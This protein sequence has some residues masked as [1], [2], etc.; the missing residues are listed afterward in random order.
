[1]GSAGGVHRDLSALAVHA[2]VTR[3]LRIH[4]KAASRV[5][6]DRNADA[7]VPAKTQRTAYIEKGRAAAR[8]A[9]VYRLAVGHRVVI[10]IIGRYRIIY[11][12][13]RRGALTARGTE[14]VIGNIPCVHIHTIA[15]IR[16]GSAG[17]GIQKRVESSGI[18]VV[19]RDGGGHGLAKE[20]M[21]RIG[22]VKIGSS[23]KKGIH[24]GVIL[25][26]GV[27]RFIGL[28]FRILDI[29]LCAVQSDTG[30]HRRS[31]KGIGY[32]KAVGLAQAV[33]TAWGDMINFIIEIRKL[34]GICSYRGDGGRGRTVISFIMK[35]DRRVRY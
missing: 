26:G 2:A 14:A 16:Y 20:N 24:S 23:D 8:R 11:A 15:L 5:V 34:S 30:N 35:Q 32:G 21:Q 17:A 3:I 1:M 6:R 33:R 10:L 13:S 31:V 22:H 29:G 4:H 28:V 9:Q 12:R 25:P 18:S 27:T 7:A 19:F